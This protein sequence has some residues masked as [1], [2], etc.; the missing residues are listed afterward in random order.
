MKS[1]SCL[2]NDDRL[3]NV[4]ALTNGVRLCAVNDYHAAR[5]H[6]KWLSVFLTDFIIA[7]SCLLYGPQRYLNVSS[8]LKARFKH[9]LPPPVGRPWHVICDDQTGVTPLW[10]IKPLELWMCAYYSA[11]VPVFK[12]NGL[13]KLKVCKN[14]LE[15][16]KAPLNSSTFLTVLQYLH[17]TSCPLWP[18]GSDPWALTLSVMC[19]GGSAELRHA[20]I[21]SHTSSKLGPLS[22]KTRWLA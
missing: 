12:T 17:H 9:L 16:C 10:W 1:D 21:N 20:D 7:S 14:K 2:W 18:C 13:N 4:A 8:L 6:Q 5:H 11:T 3:C 22:H 19:N 15:N